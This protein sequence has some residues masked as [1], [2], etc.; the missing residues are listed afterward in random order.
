MAD[1]ELQR[2]TYTWLLSKWIDESGLTLRSLAER[3]ASAGQPVT[4]SYISKV[5]S[6]SLPPASFEVTDALARAL[7][8]D[9]TP[10]HAMRLL[11]GL[12]GEWQ[13]L[14]WSLLTLV[15]D[16]AKPLL[17]QLEQSR[18]SQITHV[19]GEVVKGRWRNYGKD[20]VVDRVLEIVASRMRY[21]VHRPELSTLSL[22]DEVPEGSAHQWDGFW[23]VYTTIDE[24]LARGADY[25][26]RVQDA[27]MTEAGIMP[28]DVILIKEGR[29]GVASG[30]LVLIRTGG[31]V[32]ARRYYEVKDGFH[33]LPPLVPGTMA[34]PSD[35]EILG[36]IRGLTRSL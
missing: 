22:F 2:P 11:E 28:G 21:Q 12:D 20:Q 6:G 17:E 23:G 13:Q 32:M 14:F 24:S 34:V 29:D 33:L 8:K 3:C 10:L 36:I 30:D 26:L 31:A 5:R 25:A 16:P 9:P 7:G 27:S 4:Y 35:T 1:G 19:L 18:V 15:L